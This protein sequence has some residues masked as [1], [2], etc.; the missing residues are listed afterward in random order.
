MML[1]LTIIIVSLKHIIQYND[2]I[3]ILR[4]RSLSTMFALLMILIILIP[5]QWFCYCI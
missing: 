2:F 4:E 5:I 3:F 1:I